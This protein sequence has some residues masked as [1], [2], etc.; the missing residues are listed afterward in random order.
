[1]SIRF[2]VVDDAPFVRE[3]LKSSLQDLGA[4][5]VGEAENGFEALEVFRK[6]LPELVILDLVMPLKNGLETAL[7]MNEI[8]PGA[9]VVACST[10]DQ[11][12]LV[13]R[14][15]QNGCAAYLHKPFSK[16]DL[17]KILKEFF[18]KAKTSLEGVAKR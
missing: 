13:Q 2:I 8:W 7:E 17:Q 3:L 11:E 14:A 15:L 5:C 6:T 16:Q 9:I 12:A 4:L 18:P 1:M 10:I